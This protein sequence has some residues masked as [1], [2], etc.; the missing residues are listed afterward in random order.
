MMPATP[1]PPLARLLWRSV[2]AALATI[3]LKTLAW[4]LTGSVGLLSDAA[5]SLVN[6]AAALF[7]LVIVHWAARP[8]DEEHP[9]GHEK[10]DYLSAGV[11][12]L[13][14]L[15][16]AVTIAFSATR[17][18]LD[19]QPI[20]DVGVGL[21]ISIA[22]SAINL[23]VARMLI[24]AGREHRSIVLE[25]DG[26]HLMTDVW[27]SVGVVAGVG[28]VAV[29]GWEPL[30]PLIALL[31][32][33]NIV[34]TGIS[35]VRRFTAGLMDR[36]LPLEQRVAFDDVLGRCASERVRFHALRTRSAGPRAFVSVH[37]L[38]PG[39]WTV[40]RG[41]DLVEQVEHDLRASLQ[42]ATVFTHLEPLDD[43]ASFADTTLD[44]QGAPGARR[45]S[46]GPSENLRAPPTPR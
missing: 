15:L 44:R 17:R 43:P 4:V 11:E 30:D 40:Q 8:P 39:D 3:A 25:A 42:H 45:E 27:T 18:L 24:A 6:L 16:A 22:A 14:V 33:V 21:T 34:I 2:A 10:A 32:A 36:A 46:T 26:R 20:S 13:L 38:V 29:S 23:V 5:E 41:H 35:L 12:G 9:Y 7:A 1:R 31:V 19:P 37:V 28:L